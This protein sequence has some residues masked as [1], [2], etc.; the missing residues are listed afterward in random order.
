MKDPYKE[1]IE[2]DLLRYFEGNLPVDEREAVERWILE[3]EK[4][5][6]IAKDI[7]YIYLASDTANTIQSIDGEYAL[8]TFNTK[9]KSKKRRILLQRLQKVAAFLLIPL[10]GALS[11]I[12]LSDNEPLEYIEV[13]VTSG[14]TASLYTP[15]GTK[16][17]LNSGSVL[18]YP[19][20]F[21]EKTRTVSLEGEGYFEVKKADKPFIVN[22]KDAV[23]VEV[24][25]T[26]FNLVAYPDDDF[27]AL[28]LVSGSVTMAYNN[29]ANQRKKVNVIP[30]QKVVFDKNNK[31]IKGQAC[32][33]DTDIA[34]KDGRIVLRDT[35]LEEVL[36]QLSRRF[37]VQFVIKNE[38]LKQHHYTGTFEG[39]YLFRILEHLR[40]SS[41]I[42]YVVEA[43]QSE[44][45]DTLTKKQ[46]I[47]LY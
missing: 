30:D 44:P 12:L 32:I 20:K 45:K 47:E 7:Y 33:V 2:S 4:N 41:G 36:M 35:P 17:F 8:D 26:E 21:D 9:L 22:T 19:N 37:D 13:K 46:T 38:K 10:I 34:W 1:Q 43:K 40:F 16:I 24:T 6:K 27:T 28:T 15:D 18:K 42:Q 31:T 3:S 5:K 23:Q 11:Y 39:Q 25:G 29:A 14:M